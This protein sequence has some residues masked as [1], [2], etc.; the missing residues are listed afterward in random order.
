MWWK[1][2][3]NRIFLQE[4]ISRDSL[5]MIYS[6]VCIKALEIFCMKLLTIMLKRD[7]TP[8]ATRLFQLPMFIRYFG[9]LGVLL[10]TSLQIYLKL[11]LHGSNAKYVLRIIFVFA[12]TSTFC[13]PMK[14]GVVNSTLES[15]I[16][17]KF[18]LHKAQVKR[19]CRENS[20]SSFWKSDLDK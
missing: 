17:N 11:N 9:Y 14:I 1:D 10:Q 3:W 18:H 8:Y 6:C 12:V 7:W 4:S 13:I 2:S 19:F 5:Q 15:H 16:P 20:S